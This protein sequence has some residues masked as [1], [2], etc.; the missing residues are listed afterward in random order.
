MENGDAKW[1]FR[2]NKQL[3]SD[4]AMNVTIRSVR[5]EIMSRLNP[6][7]ERPVIPMAQGD[8]SYFSC[9]RT[10]PVA[11]DAIVES[12]RSAK[13]NCYSPIV[14]IPPA[15]RAVAEHLSKD[16]PFELSPDNV[17][18]TVGCTQAIEII[19]TVLTNPGSNV[20]IPRPG[21]PYY[22][23]WAA[24]THLEVRH[25]DLLPEKGWE[26]D[27]DSVEALADQNTAAIVIINPGNPCGSVFSAEHLEKIA[28]L[29]SQ[30]GIMVIADEVYDHLVFGSKPF[31]PMGVFA[32]IAPVVTV[33]SLSKRWIVP[34]WRLGWLVLNDPIG[35]LRKSGIIE[36]IENLLN[37]SADPVTFVQGALPQILEKTGGDFFSKIKSLLR[38]NSDICYDMIKEIPC[39]DCPHKP[40][41]SMFAMV[42]LNLSL[43]E[44]IE[45]DMGFCLMLSSEESVV[46]LPGFTVGMSGWLR[47]MFAMEPS[48]LK[49]GLH[50]I[51]AFCQRHGKE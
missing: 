51:K 49:D 16:L 48:S 17:Y 42:K 9:F 3:R 21:Y 22:E 47:I 39:I 35:I 45:S 27:L 13:F 37:I 4:S 36:S 25:Y 30:L 41:G 19:L 38:E 15:R 40:E 18:I 11:E 2:G 34:G 28:K 1:R 44:G 31:V 50:R 43:L 26:V 6:Q 29:A 5:Q 46:A 32:S 23:S 8:P 12:V 7:D 14:G 10:A 20:L 33:G 24:F